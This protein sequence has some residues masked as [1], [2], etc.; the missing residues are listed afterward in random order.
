MVSQRR[1]VWHFGASKVLRVH[2]AF[3]ARQEQSH[4]IAIAGH[5]PLAVLVERNDRVIERLAQRHTAGQM[6]RVGAVRDKPGRLW[7]DAGLLEEHR[8]WDSGP[9]RT[10]REAMDLLYGRLDR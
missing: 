10:R 8:E 4:G 7:V 1:P 6:R 9:I 3:P 2:V 5:Q